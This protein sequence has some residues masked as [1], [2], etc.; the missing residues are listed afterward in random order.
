MIHLLHT[1]YDTSKGRD[2]NLVRENIM[3]QQMCP[4][5]YLETSM[6]FTGGMAGNPGREHSPDERRKYF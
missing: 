2:V 1:A 6:K 5:Q 4:G 3:I